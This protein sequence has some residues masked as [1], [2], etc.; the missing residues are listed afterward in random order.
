MM[1]QA[2]PNVRERLWKLVIDKSTEPPTYEQ[3]FYEN[4][5]EVERKML[6]PEE[7]ALEMAPLR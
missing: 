7:A 5:T 1:D 3:V 4:G 6:T 2:T